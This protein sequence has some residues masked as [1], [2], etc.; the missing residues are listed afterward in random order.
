MLL[1]KYPNGVLTIV[2]G[3]IIIFLT[4]ISFE[5]ICM[6]SRYT[7]LKEKIMDMKV[8][9]NKTDYINKDLTLMIENSNRK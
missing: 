1:I 6:E 7:G 3:F 5:K 4:T 9:Y 8:T 2:G